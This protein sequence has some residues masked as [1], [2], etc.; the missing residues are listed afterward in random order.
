M[1]G[2]ASPL[3]AQESGNA[4]DTLVLRNKR[5]LAVIIDSVNA[6][7]VWFH[8]CSDTSSRPGLM[9]RGHIREIRSSR[10]L[11]REVPFIADPIGLSGTS[12]TAERVWVFSKQGRK[13]IRLRSGIR[14]VVTALDQGQRVKFR[15]N[16]VELDSLHLVIK[17][18]QG[19]VLKL[20][21]YAI[22][23]LKIQ[24]KM[25]GWLIGLG[26]LAILFAVVAFVF[27]L[28]LLLLGFIL[29]L[30][31]Q[32]SPFKERF[33]NGGCLL[34]FLALAGG[35]G[36]FVASQPHVLE[37]PFGGSWTV[38]EEF[39]TPELPTLP[40]ERIPEP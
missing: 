32:S 30:G 39:T 37:G 33:G 17:T 26:F 6:E 9:P 31:G 36:L 22:S 10:N 1:V 8:A 18:P 34:V 11:D 3:S 25:A 27:G 23:K 28:L 14:I 35:T 21:K 4:C 38:R 19:Q 15:G 5:V 12:R 13:D 2:M 20:D 7:T 24:K 40:E 16:F 29:L